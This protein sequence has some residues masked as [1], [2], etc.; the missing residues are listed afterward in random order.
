MPPWS[1]SISTDTWEALVSMPIREQ[2]NGRRGDFCREWK[3][4]DRKPHKMAP[5]RKGRRKERCLPP[6][7][8]RCGISEDREHLDAHHAWSLRSATAWPRQ[9]AALRRQGRSEEHTSELQSLM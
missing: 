6:R 1:K 9:Y 4:F 8:L 5:W 2:P 7:L 3:S